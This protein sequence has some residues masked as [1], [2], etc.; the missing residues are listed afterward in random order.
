MI[1]EQ[2]LNAVFD[3]IEGSIR[4]GVTAFLAFLTNIFGL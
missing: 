2:H 4:H 1:K 3:W